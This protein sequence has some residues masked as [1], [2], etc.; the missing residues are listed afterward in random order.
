MEPEIKTESQNFICSNPKCGRAFAN[1]IFVQ[2][3]CSEGAA[4][5]CACP[6]C[7]TEIKETIDDKGGRQQNTS[8]STELRQ[9][10]TLPFEEK[11]VPNISETNRCSRH[12][13]YMSQLS[14]GRETPDECMI[15]KKL[16]ECKL[17]NFDS[18]SSRNEPKTSVIEEVKRSVEDSTVDTV[19]KELSETMEFES[20]TDPIPAEFSGNHFV[21][22]NLGI[23]YASWRGTVCINKETLSS[24]GGK[25]K[26]VD[27]ETDAGKEMR[28]KVM[29]SEDSRKGI[30]LIPDKMQLNLEIKKGELVRVK[31][32]II[33]DK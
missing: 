9:V 26:E 20:K 22:E 27:I 14:V 7:L 5:Y 32:I 12:F 21:V 1:P 13:G 19:K 10:E 30:I 11:P 24:W 29:P 4:S 8:I 28:C 25:I 31:P 16:I 2:N 15:C 6:H 33:S 17:S 3:L 23:L 18:A